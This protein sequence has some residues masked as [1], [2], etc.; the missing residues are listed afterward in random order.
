LL[1]LGKAGS[2]LYFPSFCYVGH[3]W[4]L[5]TH[6]THVFV[7]HLHQEVIADSEIQDHESSADDS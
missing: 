2:I 3:C 4:V 7:I 1:L 5:I 6:I